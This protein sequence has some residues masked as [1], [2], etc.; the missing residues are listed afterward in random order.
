[1]A[2]QVHGYTCQRRRRDA[3][4]INAI[5]TCNATKARS[6]PSDGAAD[7]ADE[8]AD[9]AAAAAAG[10]EEDAAGDGA[11]GDRSRTAQTRLSAA[12]SVR[13]LLPPAD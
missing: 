12:T 2:A 3:I 7:V 8:A 11:D 5:S 10:E 4:I 9:A 6:S 13:R 1:M